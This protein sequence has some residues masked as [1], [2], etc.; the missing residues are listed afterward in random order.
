MCA[1]VGREETYS[2]DKFFLFERRERNNV[3]WSELGVVY[4][5]KVPIEAKMTGLCAI[6]NEFVCDIT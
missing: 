5:Q 6:K 3:Q 1:S 2:D 4:M